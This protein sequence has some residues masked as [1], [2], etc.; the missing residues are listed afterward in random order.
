MIRR[1]SAFVLSVFFLG[2]PGLIS[3]KS[4]APPK[5]S[6]GK[7]A[8]VA[9]VDAH[10]PELVDLANQVWAFAET[11]LKEKRSA[12]VLSDY[13]EAQGFKVERGVAGM[14]TAFVATFGE[15]K[16][17]I[18]ILGEYD[19]L[20]G[21][22]QKAQPTQEPLANG[23]PGHGCGH[24]LFGAAS[25]GAAVAVKELIAAGKL[26]GTV[27]FY[28]TPAEESVGGKLYMLREGLF[29][30]VDVALA[31]HPSD[32]TRAD[33]K[34]TQALVD[35]V[36][37]F[38]GKAAHAAFDPWNGRSALDGL[39][40]FTHALNM[41]REHVRPSV[42]MHYVIQD[43]GDVPN[44]V[45]DHAKVWA[46]VRDSKHA[47][48]DELMERVRKIAQGAALAADVES[49][50]RIQ[51]GDYEMLVNRAGERLLQANME[52]LGPIQY[53]EQEQEFAKKIQAETHTETK[54]LDGSIQPLDEHPGDPEGGSTD[55][56]DVSWNVPILHVSVTTAPVAAPWHAWPV[57]ASG[58][59]SVGHKG[60]TFAA[61]T[62]A[63]TMVDLFEQPEKRAEIRKEFEESTKGVVY[64][65]YIPEGPPP[66]PVE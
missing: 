20:P 27:R 24:N 17:V 43:G 21:I 2:L 66:L 7:V 4:A 39:E 56:A 11:A 50:L 18:A 13:A 29:K 30:D 16:P 49:T 34:S 15:G 64:K 37:E 57:V 62:L 35:F 10:R 33:T 19:A 44:V 51:S 54:G 42:R 59:M 60:M 55:V 12:K 9:S 47:S 45:P 41:M 3:A 53:T 22:S 6:P 28:G 65:G 36:V 26:H 52:W 58:G 1:R 8:A 14:P 38:Q 23:A 25:L 5:A 61:K 48:V 46:W 32:E 31:W 40:I 63:A